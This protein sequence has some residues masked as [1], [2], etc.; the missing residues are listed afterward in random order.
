MS[1]PKIKLPPHPGKVLGDLFGKMGEG[2]SSAS[3]KLHKS[4]EHYEEDVA[5]AQ[6]K[7]ITVGQAKH[8]RLAR[9]A[10]AAG[11]TA[12]SAFHQEKAELSQA[13]R[14]YRDGSGTRNAI[15]DAK[16]Q[17]GSAREAYQATRERHTGSRVATTRPAD[18]P[19]TAPVGTKIETFVPEPVK[20]GLTGGALTRAGYQNTLNKALYYAF[21]LG[22]NPNLPT[23]ESYT[24]YKLAA[25]GSVGPATL[26]AIAFYETLF[27]PGTDTSGS[28]YYTTQV[29]SYGPGFSTSF[30][31]E[32]EARCDKFGVAV[33][34]HNEAIDAAVART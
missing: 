27:P 30:V 11:R 15:G 2:L 22:T 21:A 10:T 6:A 5:E 31:E 1:S 33:A 18:P 16:K 14:A 12:E 23:G 4:A 25:D 28:N 32:I 7:N 3:D 34:S 17:F 13:R 26:K 24:D 20:S 9:E 19:P 29:G 8:I